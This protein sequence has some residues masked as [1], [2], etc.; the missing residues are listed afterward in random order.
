[1]YVIHD[2]SMAVQVQMHWQD[3][4]IAGTAVGPLSHAA[5]FALLTVHAHA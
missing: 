2:R 3:I 4:V 5:A 1:M